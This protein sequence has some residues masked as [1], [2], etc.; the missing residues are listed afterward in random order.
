MILTAV[1]VVLVSGLAYG[2]E[3]DPGFEHLKNYGPMMGTW[4]YEGPLLEDVPDF[5]DK[6]GKL[7]FQVSWK[8]ILDKSVVEE[9]W[10]VEFEGGDTVAGKALIGWNAKEKQLTY[11]GMDSTGAMSLGTVAFD[12]KA[13]SSTLTEN[14]IGAD[15][16]DTEFKGIV[17]KTGKDTLTWQRL[18][19]VG[20]I[21]EGPSPEYT[22][23][24]VKRGK[25]AKAAK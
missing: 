3:P 20:G 5:A 11:G 10:S 2:Q 21:V 23:K 1:A 4:R 15:G 9:N 19:G 22:F 7:V 24:K 16:E 18:K 14:G 12:T 17:K 25:R 13:K 6:G 8:W